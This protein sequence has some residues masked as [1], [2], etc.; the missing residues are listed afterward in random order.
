MQVINRVIYKAFMGDNE[1]IVP[2]RVIPIH[3]WGIKATQALI[4]EQASEDGLTTTTTT[5]IIHKKQRL[6]HK[7][8][9]NM[10]YKELILDNPRDSILNGIL[11]RRKVPNEY[12]RLMVSK[13]AE[14]TQ[15]MTMPNVKPIFIIIADLVTHASREVLEITI[16]EYNNRVLNN[17]I[18]ASGEDEDIKIVPSAKSA[19]D[20]LEKVKIKIDGQCSVCFEEFE[21]E[22]KEI[23]KMPCSHFYHT[24]CIG[25]WLEY[26]HVCPLCRFEMPKSID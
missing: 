18:R 22:A 1:K 19:I 20:K 5:T 23:T 11:K 7:K 14:F 17:V 26:N 3:I 24:Y 16:E 10:C 6:L 2:R 9:I 8:T 25:K 4:R 12:R 21:D 13:I 15:S